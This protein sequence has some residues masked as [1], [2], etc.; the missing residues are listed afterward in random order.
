MGMVL[1]FLHAFCWMLQ[2]SVSMVGALQWPVGGDG[3]AGLSGRWTTSVGS[4]QDLA[5]A[6]ALLLVF[7]T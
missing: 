1:G 7:I 6:A 2:A 5:R 4:R 3:T